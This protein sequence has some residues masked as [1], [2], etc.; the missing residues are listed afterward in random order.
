MTKRIALLAVAA[1]LAAAGTASAQKR[2]EISGLLG[3][4]YSDGV[5]GQ[6]VLAG[7]GE[8]YDSIEPKD[9]FNWGFGVGVLVGRNAEVGFL[10]GQQMS[11]LQVGGTTTTDV[12]DFNINTYHGYFAYNF[13]APESPVRPYV[14]VGLGATN[15]GSV[16]FTRANGEPD[17]TG[18]ETQFST[19]WGGGIKIAGN[20]PIGAR[21]GVRWT[22]TYIKTD[23]AGWWC[24]PW[25]GCYVVGNAQYSNQFEFSGGVM[26][27][28]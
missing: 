27:R 5:D 8:I 18:S 20:S 1:M 11:T 14:L 4:T 3:Y 21:I 13:G 23:T 22:P 6:G 17:E 10:F 15:Y 7:N 28:F 19:T 2:V 24:D 9:S 12:G 26:L 25:W 16:S